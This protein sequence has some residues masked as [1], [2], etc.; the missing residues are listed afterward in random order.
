V[1]A[2][3]LSRLNSM[4]EEWQNTEAPDPASNRLPDGK[5]TVVVDETRVEWSQYGDPVLVWQMRV[6]TG[7]FAGRSIFHRNYCRQSSL[8]WLKHDL[9]VAGLYLNKLSELA[10][11]YK[12]TGRCRT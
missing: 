5:Y 9:E 10:S 7:N 12:G 6:D 2:N 11:R 3:F 4:E 8:K 1:D